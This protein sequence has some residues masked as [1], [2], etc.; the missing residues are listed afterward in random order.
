[1]IGHIFLEFLQK[2][3]MTIGIIYPNI[4]EGCLILLA[5]KVCY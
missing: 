4:V 5:F 1:M 2:M 3:I